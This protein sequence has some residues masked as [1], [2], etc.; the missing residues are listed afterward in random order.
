MHIAEDREHSACHKAQ[1]IALSPEMT[2]D[3]LCTA[4]AA[5]LLNITGQVPDLVT[6]VS[7]NC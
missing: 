1:V 5:L 2:P 6:R 3:F 4:T 7:C